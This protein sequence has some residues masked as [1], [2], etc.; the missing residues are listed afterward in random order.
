[1]LVAVGDVV[2]SP[3]GEELVVREVNLLADQITTADGTMWFAEDLEEIPAPDLRD[4]DAVERWLRVSAQVIPR[5]N[6]QH[7][8]VMCE[9]K[10]SACYRVD[11][12]EAVPNTTR[13]N[14]FRTQHFA[15]NGTCQCVKKGCACLS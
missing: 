6:V 5:L 1:M 9:C 4:P 8:N 10:C 14:N 12:W 11:L 7:R 3:T 15:N 13:I 2:L